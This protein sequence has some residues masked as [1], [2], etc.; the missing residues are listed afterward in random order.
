MWYRN[1]HRPRLFLW[2]LSLAIAIIMV[3]AYMVEVQQVVR[4]QGKVIP[5]GNNKLV[6]H[7]EGGIISEILVKEG[8]IVEQGQVLFKIKNEFNTAEL[9]ALDIER[10]SL[11]IKLYRIRTQLAGKQEIIFPNTLV[12]QAPKV[13]ASEQKLLNDIYSN[14]IKEQQILQAAWKRKQHRIKELTTQKKNLKIELDLVNK[15]L[16]LNEQL[17]KKGAAS[18]RDVLESQKRYRSL[19]TTYDKVSFSIPTAK[20]ESKEAHSRYEQLQTDYKLKLQE[21]LIKTQATMAKVDA[22]R[23][24][25]QDR[26]VRSDVLA[27]VKGIVNRLMINTVGGI[28]R[29]GDPLASITPL[30]KSLV[31]EA[32]VREADRAEIWI[33]QPVKVKLRAYD[34]T[35]YGSLDGEISLISA[36]SFVENRESNHY[37]YQV[38]IKIEQAIDEN[39]PILP[40]MISDVDM[41]TGKKRVLAYLTG[42]ILRSWDRALQE[43]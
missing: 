39:H 16:K 5:T 33:G 36:D 27:S 8:D 40:G 12:E 28:I 31:I 2:T 3:W 10:L 21:E 1:D 13:V 7:L 24:A 30:G 6:Q 15:E 29:S 25:F 23:K 32:K 18:V 19:K 37:F 35:T 11:L 14:Y 42:P 9:R 22:K 34:H 4:A 17:E 26:L 38:Q 20:S 41:L 43:Q